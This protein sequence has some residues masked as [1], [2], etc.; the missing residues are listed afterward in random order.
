MLGIA[1]TSGKSVASQARRRAVGTPAAMETISST[2]SSAP[3]SPW[4]TSG[5]TWGFTARTSRSLC[6]A[7]SRLSAPR[8]IPK[9]AASPSRRAGSGSLTAM[10][11]GGCPAAISPPMSARAM[12]PPPMK[13]IVPESGGRGSEDC[14][15]GS[16]VKAQCKDSVSASAACL[17]TGRDPK[18]AVPIRIRFAPSAIAASKSSLIPIESVSISG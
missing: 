9:S 13:P 3:R 17:R 2:R 14:M 6:A 4:Q 18:R 16:G 10:L 11:A 15:L 7:T 12:L 1:R 8:A 5:R